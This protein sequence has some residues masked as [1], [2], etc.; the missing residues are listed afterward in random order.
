MKENCFSYLKII[1]DTSVALCDA[2]AKKDTTKLDEYLERSE[3]AAKSA[4]ELSVRQFVP[5]IDREDIVY[6]ALRGHRLNAGLC[7]DSRRLMNTA[8]AAEL[9]K[10]VSRD[11][12]LISSVFEKEMSEDLAVPLD[13]YRSPLGI[14]EGNVIK[15]YVEELLDYTVRTVIKNT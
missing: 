14:N 10:C 4:V 7:A 3:R 13:S 9:L 12:R 6:L 2:I 5:P 15:Q 11:C 8:S 1:T